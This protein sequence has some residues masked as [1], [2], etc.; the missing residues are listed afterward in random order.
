MGSLVKSFACVA[1]FTATALMIGPCHAAE[2]CKMVKVSEGPIRLEQGRLM[3]DGKIDGRPA[4]LLLDVGAQDTFIFGG[5]LKPLK[6]SSFTAQ[7]ISLFGVDGREDAEYV[8][9][10]SLEAAGR[11]GKSL[12]VYAA[13][14]R[15]SPSFAGTIGR[16]FVDPYD[17]EID[18]AAGVVRLW[19][20]KGCGDQSLAYWTEQPIVAEMRHDDWTTPFL[21]KLTING[22]PFEA[23][24]A[25]GAPMSVVDKEVA[26]R[27]GA[28]SE[29]VEGYS[30]AALDQIAIG[31]EAIS[32]PK[33]RIAALGENNRGEF[34]HSV[35]SRFSLPE[36][37]AMVLGVDYLKAH[38]VLLS[39]SQHR[40]YASYGGG[41]IFQPAAGP[42]RSAP[43]SP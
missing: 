1:A 10:D 20:V 11:S 13:G 43:P 9:L 29:A 19:S 26:R 38:R 3:I 42:V 14:A 25:S 40:F 35:F 31:G 16:D 33:L 30:V 37:A 34:S 39:S 2:A 41:K 22:R 15:G 17:I 32:H 24:V 4:G 8:L 6:L 7:N 28:T 18:L 5:A 21:V 23:E 12:K 27:L 36:G